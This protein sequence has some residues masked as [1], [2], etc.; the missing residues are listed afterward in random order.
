MYRKDTI[1][2]IATPGG[3]GGVAIIRVSGPDATAIAKQVVPMFAADA[4]SHRLY[5]STIVDRESRPIDRGLC[6][7]MRAPKSY[8]G[9]DVVEIHCHGGALLARTVLAST[10]ARGARAAQAG[11]F[12]LRAFLNGKLDLAQAESVADAVA[13]RTPAALRV[14]SAHLHGALSR[15]VE[16]FRDELVGVAARL[17]VHI[18]FT[19][20]DVGELEVEGLAEEVARVRAEIR[21][22]AATFERGRRLREGARVA[23]VGKPNVGK[24]S[25]LNR[26]LG[27]DRSIV[28]AIPGTTR[29]TIEEE[30]DLGGAPVV[31][32]D[33]AG[34]RDSDDEVE[35]LGIERTRR[36]IGECD[37]AV[38]VLDGSAAL[39]REDRDALD[40]TR[41]QSRIILINKI[42]LPATCDERELREA[43]GGSLC[44]KGSMLTGAGIGELCDVL[45]ARLGQDPATNASL[46]ITRVRQFEALS[47]SAESLD[48]ALQSLR[49]HQPPDIVAV[50]VMAAL[51]HLREIVGATSPEAVLD[52][53]FSEFCIGK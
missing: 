34:V 22:L 2:A 25:L 13:A 3:T 48:H 53:I 46:S 44:V 8:T 23:I 37:H 12:T 16:T 11:E 36:V 30:I 52:R 49:D 45:S 9:E 29:D 31:F 17:E 50:D 41:Q 18:D 14:A 42:D 4:E 33:T 38:V 5:A 51:D 1:A 15:R 26:L 6:V 35:R 39:T 19:E 47:S 40:A 24:S 10:L 32:I 27:S 43:A 20:E 21:E 7:L 28:T